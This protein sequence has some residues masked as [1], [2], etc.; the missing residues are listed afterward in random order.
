MKYLPPYL[1]DYSPIELTFSVLK[2]WIRRYFESFRTV[3]QGDLEGLLR[4]AIENS[5][6]DR[7]AVKHSRHSAAGY[8]LQDDFEAFEQELEK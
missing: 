3:F 8:I 6:R 4:Y 5:G 7:F 2:A 1:P